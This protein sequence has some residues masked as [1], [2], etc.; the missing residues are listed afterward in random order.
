MKNWTMR[1]KSVGMFLI[2][3]PKIMWNISVQEPNLQILAVE[4][5]LNCDRKSTWSKKDDRLQR[6][7]WSRWRCKDNYPIWKGNFPARWR[8]EVTYVRRRAEHPVRLGFLYLGTADHRR[9]KDVVTDLKKEYK[10]TKKWDT[11]ACFKGT[12]KKNYGHFLMTKY[13]IIILQRK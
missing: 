12:P 3:N 6:I 9:C 13:C 5:F 2:C 7:R 8:D 4:H 11:M 10:D 1:K